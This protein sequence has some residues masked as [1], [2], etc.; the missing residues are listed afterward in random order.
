MIETLN[1][2]GNQ[3]YKQSKTKTKMN[4]N[5]NQVGAAQ[6]VNVQAQPE[7][8]PEAQK[9]TAGRPRTKLTKVLKVIKNGDAFVLATKGKPKADA[10]MGE[11]TV[12]WDYDRKNGFPADA[13]VTNLHTVTYAKIETPVVA[14]VAPVVAESAPVIPAIIPPI[15]E[16]VVA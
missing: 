6:A 9:K 7:A 3:K 8:Q 16:P 12:A 2:C 5:E 13:K 14:P 1:E 11:I 10:V 15:V 4:G